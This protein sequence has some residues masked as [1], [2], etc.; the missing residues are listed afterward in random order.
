MTPLKRYSLL[1]SFFIVFS[2]VSNNLCAQTIVINGV[3]TAADTEEIL[4]GA[5]IR[6]AD[7]ATVSDIDGVFLLTVADTTSYLSIDY[8][9]YETAFVFLS[10][11]G[12]ISDPI[13]ELTVKLE[14]SKNILQTATVTSGKFDKALGEITVSMEV[15]KPK[16]IEDISAPDLDQALEK[17]PGVTVIDGQVNIRG[18]SG[19]SYGAGSRVLLLIDDIPA[20]QADAGSPNWDDIPIELTN[21]I[22]VLKGASSALFGSSAM[23]G[24]INLRTDYAKEKTETKIASFYTTYQSPADQTKQWWA[25]DR[26]TI[27]HDFVSYIT[28]KQKFG[29]LDLVGSIFV[30]NNQEWNKNNYNIYQRGA[31]GLRYRLDKNWTVALNGIYRTGKNSSFFYWQNADSLALTGA[32]AAFS[33]TNSNRLILDPS[34]QYADE[35]GNRHKLQTR[36]YRVRN[37]ALNNQSNFSTLYYGE[38]QYQKR[39]LAQDLVL[40]SGLVGSYTQSEAELYSNSEFSSNNLAAYLQADKE[41]FGKLNLSLGLRYEQNQINAPDSIP[42]NGVNMAAGIDKEAKPVFRFGANYQMGKFSYLRA[43]FGQGYLD[44][45]LKMWVIP[46]F[47]VLIS[48]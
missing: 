2:F 25:D 37:N 36:L 44:F 5:T 41:F 24:I 17:I 42:I 26:D 47:V 8:V 1:Y 43:S 13:T 32:P 7:N 35:K 39:F 27:P 14:P 4:I 31:I 23:N 21:Q 46:S 15:L 3:V 38:Y 29:K 20:L 6:S 28:H 30:R 48:M 11:S 10:G 9:G 45:N 18:G 12:P 22:E 19:F 40:S 34:I 16:L 33:V